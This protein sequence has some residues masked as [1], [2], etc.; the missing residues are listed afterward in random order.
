MQTFTLLIKP[1]GS[2]CN[3]DC[4]YCFYKQRS[5]EVGQ[6]RQRMSEDVLDK[7]IKDYMKLRLPL[8]EFAWQGGEPTL[9][10]LDFYKRAVEL[11]Q[12]YSVPGQ[13]VSNSLQTNGILLNEDWCRF[14]HEYNFLVGISLDGPEEMHNYYRRDHSG[15]GTFER[16]LEAIELCEEYDVAFNTLTLLNNKNVEYPD[17][18]F[19]F[20]VELDVEYLQ[21]IPCV[22]VDRATGKVADFSI[23]PQQYGNFLC[24]VFDCWYEHGPGNIHIRDFDTFLDCLA[25]YEHTICTFNRQC[26]QYI[27]IEHSGDAFC[28][29]FFVEPKWKLGNILETPIEKLAASDCKRAFA[30]AKSNISNKCL[31]CRELVFCRA[32]CLK[33]RIVSNRENFACE[34]YFCRSYRQF[35]DHA[36]PRIMQLGAALR[37]SLQSDEGQV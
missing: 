29:D 36:M 9:M 35:F 16:V 17:M 1:T 20:F 10:G 15:G 21:F 18:L 22:E 26:S 3:L 12:K 13:E 28:C 32:G 4:K 33:D 27:V 11:Q 8:S 2:D 37:A 5:P 30:R 24:R 25:C 14:L 19:D 23:T 6:G 7:L 31:V 34:S